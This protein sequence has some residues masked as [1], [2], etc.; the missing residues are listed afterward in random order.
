MSTGYEA[1]E[2]T[3]SQ[4]PELIPGLCSMKRLGV[5]Q[6]SLDRI[7]VCRRSFPGNLLGF[8]QQLAGTHLYSWVER[9]TTRVKCFAQEHNTV[10]PARA[11]TRTTRSGDE[12]TNPEASAP[13]NEHRILASQNAGMTVWQSLGR[14]LH[15]SES[16]NK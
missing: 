16:R 6:L 11:Q 8:P 13:P 9:G 1:L 14:F 3:G 2:L 5:F 10:S 4:L 15:Q 7:L 12:H